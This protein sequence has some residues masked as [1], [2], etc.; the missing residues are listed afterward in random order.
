MQD[1]RRMLGQYFATR[2]EDAIDRLWDE[3]VLNN[4]VVEGWRTEHMRTPYKQ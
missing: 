3:G 2:A 4:D 1:I